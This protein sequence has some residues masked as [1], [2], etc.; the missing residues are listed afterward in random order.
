MRPGTILKFE[1]G[2]VGTICYRNLDGEGGVWGRH[3]FS[4]IPH[5]VNDQWPAPQ[6]MLREKEIESLMQKH[7]GNIECVGD[8]DYE[9]LFVPG[10]GEAK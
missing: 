10:E 9:V 2:R 4:G 5:N 7:H 8:M 1:D 6:F 3:D